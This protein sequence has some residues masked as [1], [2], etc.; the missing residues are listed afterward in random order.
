MK[1]EIQNL[2]PVILESNNTKRVKKISYR[3]RCYNIEPEEKEKI[4]KKK[5]C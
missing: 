2:I 1:I 4:E 5:V 3:Q